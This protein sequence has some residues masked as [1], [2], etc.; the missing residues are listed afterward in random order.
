MNALSTWTTIS[1]SNM[2]HVSQTRQHLNT[3]MDMT[4]QYTKLLRNTTDTYN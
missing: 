2:N 1:A 4:R 3:N